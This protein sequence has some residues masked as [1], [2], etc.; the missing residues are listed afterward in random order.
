MNKSKLMVERIRRAKVLFREL[1]YS[2]DV[3]EYDGDVF[4]GDFRSKD[5]FTGSFF[6]ERECKFLEISF[7][8]E[9]SQTLADFLR[10]KIESVIES[11]YDYGCYTAFEPFDDTL[12]LSV[13]SKTYFSGLSYQSL[14]DTIADF[15]DCIETLQITL[16]I[17]KEEAE[18]TAEKE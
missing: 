9:F 5:G 15:R 17:N 16:S 14:R 11:C 3:V 8:F 10:S 7:T 1:G 6:I 12:A 13:C 18:D 2:V 4:T